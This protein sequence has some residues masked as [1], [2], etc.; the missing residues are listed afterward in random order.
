VRVGDPDRLP[1]NRRSGRPGRR[2]WNHPDSRDNILLGNTH[3][4]ALGARIGNSFDRR[5]MKAGETLLLMAACDS[6]D[7][8]KSTQSVKHGPGADVYSFG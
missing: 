7:L 8:E 1:E 6:Q 2:H 4:P 3:R 5:K